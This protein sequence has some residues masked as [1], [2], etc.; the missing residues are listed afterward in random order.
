MGGPHVTTPP[1]SCDPGDFINGDLDVDGDMDMEDF[2][3][4][5]A[6]FTGE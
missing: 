1:P 4:F 2:A 5:Q 3:S 6:A